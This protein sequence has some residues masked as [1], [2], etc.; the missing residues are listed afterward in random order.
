MKKN[1]QKKLMT[2]VAVMI[3]AGL[4]VGLVLPLAALQY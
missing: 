3:I 4:L 1:T 2:I